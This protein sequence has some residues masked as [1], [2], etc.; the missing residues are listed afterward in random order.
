MLRRSFTL[1]FTALLVTALPGCAEDAVPFDAPLGDVPRADAAPPDARRVVPPFDAG[2]LVLGD[3]PRILVREGSEVRARLTEGL[4][5]DAGMRFLAMVERGVDGSVYAFRESDAALV[6]LLTGDPSL[7]T[8]AVEAIDARV[9]AEEARIAGGERAAIAG[10][11]YL[12]VG[13][14]VADLALVYDWCFEQVEPAQRARWIDY[15]NE[16]VWNV[17]HHEEA[18]WGGRPYPWTGWSVENPVNNYYSSFLEAT[19]M[20]GLATAGESDMAE[21]WLAQF[22]TTKIERELAVVFERD[23]LGGGSREGTGYGTAMFRLFWL[24]DVWEE[25]TGERIAEFTSHTRSSLPYLVHATT[26]T[27]D[28]L[29]PIGDHARDSTAALFD[30]HRLYLLELIDLFPDD[31]V[32]AIAAQYLEGSSVTRM[33]QQFEYLYDVLYAPRVAPAPLS[34]LHTVYHG[35]GTG[36][37]FVRSGWT[38]DASYLAFVAGPYTESHAHQDQGS[39]VLFSGEWLAFDENVLSHSGLLQGTDAH[40]LVRL[41]RDGE[42]VPMRADTT[43]DLLAVEVEGPVVYLAADTAPAY[44]DEAIERVL[45]RLVFVRPGIV[46]IDDVVETS[47]AGLVASWA[48]STPI[49]PRLEGASAAIVGAA[50]RLDVRVLRGAGALSVLDWSTVDRDEYS[51]GFRLDAAGAPGD[52]HF[53]TVLSIDGAV[54]AASVSGDTVSITASEGPIQITFPPGAAPPI[55]TRGG[56]TFSFD[57]AVEYQPVLAP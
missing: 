15:A 48:M 53:V 7:C 2:P 40:N 52:A 41:E 20:L 6:S 8:H 42:P 33:E 13:D 46:V 19:M 23:L 31:P 22:R 36:H 45:R 14:Y 28:R 34:G 18:S 16:A 5:S 26:P 37:V 21:G 35:E 44:R 3:H 38:E 29:A 1:L 4:T 25:T 47:D 57:G 27:L 54:S 55:V 43:S 49:A 32:A 9:T 56:A 24:Y 12:E 39:F 50:G 10:D 17:W 30:Y 51:G 11:S